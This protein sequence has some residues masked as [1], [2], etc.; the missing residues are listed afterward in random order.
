MTTPIFEAIE[1]GDIMLLNTG[2]LGE[3]IDT[4]A[5][6]HDSEMPAKEMKAYRDTLGTACSFCHTS[7]KEKLVCAKVSPRTPV[8]LRMTLSRCSARSLHIAR[9][10]CASKISCLVIFL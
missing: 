6:F 1:A 9:K 7:Q 2:V 10:R 3:D 4:S 8:F 5:L